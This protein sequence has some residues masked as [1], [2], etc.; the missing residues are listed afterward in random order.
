MNSIPYIMNASG[1]TFF[2]DGRAVKITPDDVRYTDIVDAVMANDEKTLLRLLKENTISYI[3]NSVS[4]TIKDYDNLQFI[5]RD[6][7]GVITTI[8]SYKTQILPR[9]LQKKFI[10]LWKSGCTDFTHYFKFIDNLMANPS[11]TSREEL[12]DFLSYQELPITSEGTFIAYKGVGEDMYSLHGNAETRVLQGKVNGHYQI[13][14]NPGDVIEVV[15]AD[16][17]A[18]RNNW[19]SAGL[20]VGSYDYAKGFGKRVVAVE[21]NPQDVVS[22]PTDC[23]CQKC[24]VSKYKVLNEIKEAYTSPDVEVEGIDVKECSK[25]RTPVNVEASNQGIIDEMCSPANISKTREAI[26]RNIQNHSV[27]REDGTLSP[28][29]LGGPTI[30]QGTNIA[31]LC[32]SVGRKNKI[33]RAAMLA[34][35]L[36]LGYSVSTAPGSISRFIVTL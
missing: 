10:S 30:I 31:Q 2:V 5:E 18:N 6:E 7:N 11:E 33:S 28:V 19:C 20:H 12:Y 25:D 4:E 21:V 16:V 24:R 14:N 26:E 22:V 13:R 9:C 1:W 36:R 3:I 32:G 15:V 23:E 29:F 34:L 8:A 17:D 27:N 35:V